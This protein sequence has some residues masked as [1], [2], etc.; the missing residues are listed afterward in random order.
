MTSAALTTWTPIWARFTA[1]FDGRIV[2]YGFGE[3]GRAGAGLRD[4]HPQ[5]PGLGVSCRGDSAHDAALRHAA[6]QPALHRRDPRQTPGGP[7]RSAQ[8]GCHRG[9]G[10]LRAQALVEAAGGG[11]IQD[12]PAL[13]ENRPP[14]PHS[15]GAALRPSRSSMNAEDQGALEESQPPVSYRGPRD[16]RLALQDREAEA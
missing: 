10:R 14:V 7:R 16:R 9:Q 12:T 6:T 1:R 2:T 3:A 15:A 4:H 8:G 5:E 13:E 11:C